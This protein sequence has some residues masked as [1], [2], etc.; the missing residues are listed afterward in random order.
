MPGPTPKVWWRKS[1][2]WWCTWYRK[3]QKR[4]AKGK[5][6]KTAA[7]T[8]LRKLLEKPSATATENSP[9]ARL[10]VQYLEHL[11]GGGSGVPLVGPNRM[12]SIEIAVKSFAKH[13]GETAVGR[14]TPQHAKDW[15]AEYPKWSRSTKSMRVAA[16]RGVFNWAIGEGLISR[17]PFG[18]FHG[19]G[20]DRRE[21]MPTPEEIDLIL[22]YPN[23]RWKDL[24]TA[25]VHTGARPSEVSR[26]EARNVD[27]T[28]RKWTLKSHKTRAK[29]PAPRVIWLDKAM[30]AITKRLVKEHPE[31]PIFR[32]SRGRPWKPN[33]IVDVFDTLRAKLAVGKKVTAY[34][35]RHEYI[36][37]ALTKEVD[38]ATVATMC[39]TSVQMIQKHYSHL[40]QKPA[41]MVAS[42]EKV[43]KGRKAR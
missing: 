3:K 40:L 8:A 14:L 35:F 7:E 28:L 32:N 13:F 17:Q 30:L 11:E 43:S 9:V 12:Q 25:L 2:G 19:P 10:L 6:N 39:G 5:E 24:L 41:Y 26:V 21:N 38:V 42:V 27:L 20:Y 16:I 18:K 36:T 34:T 33:T 29:K 31:G 4:L 23:P 22:A 1:D 15:L 37:R